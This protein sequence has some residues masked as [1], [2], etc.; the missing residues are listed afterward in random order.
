MIGFLTVVVATA[1]LCETV[2]VDRYPEGEPRR[3][4]SPA[5]ALDVRIALESNDWLE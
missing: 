5:A 3:L 1:D 4:S 2:D